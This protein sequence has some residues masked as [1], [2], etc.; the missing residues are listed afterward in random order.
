[1]PSIISA[2]QLTSP[3]F[4]DGELIP[5]KFTCKGE[6][7]NP[8]LKISNVPDGAESLALVMEDPDAPN[9]TFVHWTLWNIDPNTEMIPA[10]TEPVGAVEGKTSSGKT[11]YTGPCPPSG[12]HRYFIRLYALSSEIDLPSETEASDLKDILKGITLE[13]CTLMGMYAKSVD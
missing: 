12:T 10:G 3:D 6:N 2:M 1:M 13:E 8:A 9:G 11:G 7:I 4:K 5:L